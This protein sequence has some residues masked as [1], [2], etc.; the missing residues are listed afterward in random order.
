M[1][2]GNDAKEIN[3]HKRNMQIVDKEQDM[4]P[5][6]LKLSKFEANFGFF[7]AV[8]KPCQKSNFQKQEQMDQ[9]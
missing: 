2:D 9:V 3:L 6:F 4:R 5:V 1:W 7:A 8:W